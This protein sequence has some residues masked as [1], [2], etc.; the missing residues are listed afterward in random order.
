MLP[1]G[2][3]PGL[4]LRS[5]RTSSPLVVVWPH[6][7]FG[8]SKLN[9]QLIPKRSVSIPKYAPQK[10]SCNG[11]VTLPFSPSVGKSLSTSAALS[12]LM[13]TEKLLPTGHS[14]PGGVSEAI[15][16]AEPLLSRAWMIRSFES[17]DISL[18]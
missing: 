9:I 2:F 15:S 1:Y 12:Q 7:D 17:L 11:I 8:F 18:G 6:L 4:V 10:V 5:C 3:Q 14:L 13:E 16:R